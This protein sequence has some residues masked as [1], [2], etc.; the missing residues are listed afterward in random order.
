MKEPPALVSDLHRQSQSTHGVSGSSA[1]A[2]RQD[3]RE[4]P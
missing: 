2:I 1:D 3:F 4:N